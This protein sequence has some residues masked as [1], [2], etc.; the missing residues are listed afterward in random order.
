M[1]ISGIAGSNHPTLSRGDAIPMD[2][3]EK[4]K[5]AVARAWSATAPEGHDI[6][7]HGVTIQDFYPLAGTPGQYDVEAD[8]KYRTLRHQDDRLFAPKQV[9]VQVRFKEV[10]DSLGVDDIEIVSINQI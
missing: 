9:S 1:L 6:T 8:V 2:P 3:K 7:C 4:A 5:Y 10:K